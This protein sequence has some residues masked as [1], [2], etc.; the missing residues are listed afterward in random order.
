VQAVDELERGRESYGRGAW[1]EAHELLTRADRAFPLRP[2]DLELLA[3]SAYM[4]GR[5]DAYRSGLE[6]AHRAYL[7]AGEAPSAVRCAF[8]IGHNLLFRG[9]TARAGGWFARAQ[10]LLE[11]DGRDCVERGWLL[12]PLWLEQMAAGDW[13]AGRTTAAEAALIG[14]RFGDLDLVWLA[15]DEQGRALLKQGRVEEGLRLVDEAL[16]AAAAGELSPVVT[17]IVYC[18]TIAFCRDTYELR[19]AREWTEALTR[20]CETQPEMV[21]HN[22]LCLVHRAEIMQLQGAWES[23][24]EAA[25]YAAERFTEGVLNELAR[26]AALYRQGE[27]FRLRGDLDAAEAAFRE[28]SRSGHEPQPGLSL[29]RLAQGRVD[30]AAAAIRRAV[31]EAAEPLRRA[32]LLPAYVEIMLEAGELEVARSAARQLREIAESRGGDALTAMSAYACAAVALADDEAE[33]GL[34]AAR[35]SAEAWQALGAPYETARCRVSI[36]LACRSL[37]DEDTAALELEGAR[38][39]FAQMGAAPDLARVES[40]TRPASPGGVH[41]LTRREVEVLRLVAAGMTNRQI[42]SALV[43]SE[44]TVA[45]HLQN[46]F[47]KLRV[48]SRTAASA[49]AFE[50]DLV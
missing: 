45:R 18:N 15:R 12:I 22:G 33:A 34:V 40:L 37:G 43:I 32:G 26:G 24:L 28:A 10:R 48:S 17:G 20:W 8:W 3:R 14:D 46:I 5:D 50:H 35:R 9:R 27:V 7:D 1:R 21:A 13:E 36:A 4:L 30:A 49:F 6:R 42:A 39:V 41:G 11:R 2:E 44:R 19:Q 25:R 38:A 16:V 31:G 29:V 47:A 23:A